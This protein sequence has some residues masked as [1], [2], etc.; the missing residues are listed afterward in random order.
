MK[1]I[2]FVRHAKA[3]WDF[4]ELSDIQ[5]PLLDVGKKRT[6]KIIKFL[7]EKGIVPELILSSPAVRAF[8]TAKLLAAGLHY[9]ED[10]IKIAMSI[11][12]GDV[13]HI[14]NDIFALPN[15]T[16]SVMI[17]GHNPVITHLVNLFATPGVSLLPTSG[18]AGISFDTDKWEKVPESERT[19]EF[20]VYPKML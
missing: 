9:P 3:S 11:Y 1:T 15:A 2:Y 10:T 13:E 18:L 8:E 4:P 5:R 19:T 17:V 6:K 7:L 12:H 20:I 14:L 16:S